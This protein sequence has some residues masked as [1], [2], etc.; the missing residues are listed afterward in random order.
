MADPKDLTPKLITPEGAKPP[1]I[2]RE[3]LYELL[4]PTGQNEAMLAQLVPM[5]AE[6]M[7]AAVAKATTDAQNAVFDKLQ[8]ETKYGNW[9]VANYPARSVFNPKGDHPEKGLPRPEV[10]GHVF[11]VGTL[12]DSREMTHEEIDLTNKLVPGRFHGGA[13]KVTD[14]APGQTGTRALLVTFPCADPDMRANLPS[15]V[16]MLREMTADVMATA[17]A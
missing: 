11:W 5:M 9:N 16:D 6:A 7:A 8:G 15:M 2:T 4:K 10:N 3:E 1:A 14:L 12:M 13:W 17:V